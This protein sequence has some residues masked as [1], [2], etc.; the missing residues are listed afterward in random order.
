MSVGAF[1][2]LFLAGALGGYKLAVMCEPMHGIEMDAGDFRV[3]LEGFRFADNVYCGSNAI[4]LS[5]G[6]KGVRRTVVD[7]QPK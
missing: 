4:L 5:L 7:R 2:T 1:R 3:V 6:I